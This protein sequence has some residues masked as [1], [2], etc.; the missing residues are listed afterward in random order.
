[1]VSLRV[2]CPSNISEPCRTSRGS[3]RRLTPIYRY[4]LDSITAIQLATLLRQQNISISAIDVIEHPTCAGIAG[5]IKNSVEDGFLRGYDFDRFQ[6]QVKGEI[7]GYGVDFDTIEAVLPCTATQ[8]GLLSQFLDRTDD[9][10]STIPLGL[11]TW[12]PI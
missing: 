3:N 12:K 4:G 6:K 5:A 11:L 2:D 1:M 7:L 9:T 8:Q 10:I